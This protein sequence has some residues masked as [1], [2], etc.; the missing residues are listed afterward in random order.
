MTDK[1]LTDSEIKKALEESISFDEPYE[2]DFTLIRIEYI[3]DAL[4]LINRLRAENKRLF[5]LAELGN[6]RAND[7]RVMRDRALK[8]E[9]E[10]E[11]LKPFEDKIAEFK[12]H[13]R[14]EDMLVFANSLEEWL[15]FCDNLKAEAYKEFAELGKSKFEDIARVDFEGIPYFFVSKSFFD[16][17]LKELVGE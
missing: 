7:Y 6:T 16:N 4:D 14:V 17:L 9:A 8:A 15:E 5:T 12:S 1:K 2:S 3:K 13:I 10:N 11:R